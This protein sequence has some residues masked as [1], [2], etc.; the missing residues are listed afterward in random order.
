MV[1]V[2]FGPGGVRD[3]FCGGRLC[4]PFVGIGILNVRC[5]GYGGGRQADENESWETGETAAQGDIALEWNY[6][7]RKNL[8]VPCGALSSS[9][10]RWVSKS[11]C[12]FKQL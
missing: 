7:S 1:N 2:A 8:D 5:N 4:L 6:V 10:L 12:K 3:L 9:G 11:K